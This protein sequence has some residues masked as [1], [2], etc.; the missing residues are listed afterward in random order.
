MQSRPRSPGRPRPARFA[1]IAL[2]VA[3]ST[4]GCN[5][6]SPS[7]SA[8]DPAGPVPAAPRTGGIDT[9]RA[10][11]LVAQGALTIDVREPGEWE[12]GHL[13]Q[14]RLVPLAT[15]PERLAELEQ[16]AGGKDLPVVLYCRTGSRATRAKQLLEA[17]GFTRVVNG[18]GLRAMS[19]GPPPP[20]I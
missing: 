16:A 20:P 6:R 12:E 10:R 15:L 7:R 4:A 13:P 1:S 18:G 14:A 11:E 2:A 17:A 3:A 9:A 8:A 5:D 19:G